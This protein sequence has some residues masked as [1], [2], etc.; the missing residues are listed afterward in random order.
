MLNGPFQ[1]G[2]QKLCSLP[3]PFKTSYWL[4]R[5][6]DFV[7]SHFKTWDRTRKKSIQKYGTPMA[8]KPGEFE[9][10]ETNV[11]AIAA[12]RKELD[13]ALDSEIELPLSFRISLPEEISVQSQ[14]SAFEL[15]ALDDLIEPLGIEK[16]DTKITPI[17]QASPSAA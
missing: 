7:D 10:A 14:F 9:I 13:E 17:P 11:E 5:T 8:D 4:G 16:K 12:Y 1:S 2:L 6:A 3:L 15:I